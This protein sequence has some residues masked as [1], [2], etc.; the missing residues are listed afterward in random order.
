MNLNNTNHT[1]STAPSEIVADKA[2]STYTNTQAALPTVHE[3]I[4]QTESTS[5]KTVFNMADEL[6]DAESPNKSDLALS[7]PPPPADDDDT[8]IVGVA[9]PAVYRQHSSLDK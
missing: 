3:E 4:P 6:D 9:T 2:D 1:G 5:R 7:I 8:Y